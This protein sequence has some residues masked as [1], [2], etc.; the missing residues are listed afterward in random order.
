MRLSALMR[1][2]SHLIVVLILSV[3]QLPQAQANTLTVTSLNDS[4][5]GSLR[6][7]IAAATAGDTIVFS[8]SGTIAL[9]SGEISISKNLVV[10]GGGQTITISG[11]DASRVFNIRSEATVSLNVP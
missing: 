5:T 10:D 8:V 3:F 1:L 2:T 4:G 6:D 11:N 7:T 9:M